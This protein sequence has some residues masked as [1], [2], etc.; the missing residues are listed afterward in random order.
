MNE[1][2]N[3]IAQLLSPSPPYQTHTGLFTSLL[4]SLLQNKRDLN[5]WFEYHEV[6]RKKKIVLFQQEELQASKPL[7]L[8]KG[9]G[10]EGASAQFLDA[11]NWP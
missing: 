7:F 1:G 3:N 5:S 9:G 8:A 10:R 6:L 4:C 2:I 11:L